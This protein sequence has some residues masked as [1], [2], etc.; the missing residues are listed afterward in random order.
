MNGD[1]DFRGP[2]RAIVRAPMVRFASAFITGLLVG[3]WQQPAVQPVL[4]VLGLLTPAVALLVLLPTGQHTRFQHGT[5]MALWAILFGMAWQGLREPANQ[6]FHV[7]RFTEH[8][9][10]WAVRVTAL[11]ATSG[12][13]WRADAALEAL[14]DSSGHR[15]RTGPVMLTLLKD[16]GAAPRVGDRLLVH[17]PLRPIDRVPDPGGFDRRAW[18]ASRGIAHEL[19]APVQRWRRVDHVPHWTGLFTTTRERIAAWLDG[20]GLEQREKAL[21]KALVLGQR[22]ELDHGQRDAFA[23]SGTIH[24]L[25]VSGMHV[26][27]IFAILTFLF[28]WWGKGPRARRLRGLCILLALWGYAGLT[29]ASPSVLRATIMFSL[30]TLANMAEQRTDHFNSLFAAAFV[31]LLWEPRMLGQIGFQL[32]FLAVLGI[33]LFYK[34]FERLWSP[35]SPVLQ[36]VRNL[37]VVSLAAQVLTTPVSLYLFKAFPVWF[38][39]ANIVVVT[40]V[41]L[42]VN[43]SVAL[44]LLY[45]VPVIGP[46]ITTLLSWL[47]KAVGWIT[48][49]IAAWPGAYPEVRISAMGVVL[50][51]LLVFALAAWW[52]WRWRSMRW[53]AGMATALLLVHWVADASAAR[54]RSAFVVY[55]HQGH[56]LAAMVHGRDHVVRMPP[57]AVP[58]APQVATKL[59]RHVRSHGLHQPLVLAG[60]A[61]DG[62][63]E[64]G[65]TLYA[66]GSWMAPGLHVAFHSATEPLTG[67]PGT[68]PP[69][70]LVLHEVQRLDDRVL[71]LAS[72]M[73][74]PVVLAAGVAWPVRRKVQRWAEAHGRRV[75][76]VREH[77]AF[78]LER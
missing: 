4:V 57:D 66:A 14:L 23:R 12:N 13:L 53:L 77:G 70:A 24:V 8:E 44:L 10:V 69:L 46:L 65:P 35:R 41:G 29:G 22:D 1:V 34:P 61:A 3:L 39:P 55:D 51:Y 2:W 9:G 74:G 71:E 50:L 38:L 60:P 7:A 40:A 45:K 31:L 20:S 67:W 56:L 43:G 16:D 78:V 54:R 11:N 21:V 73:D 68:A 75:H 6:P 42:A 58:D 17:A 28:G 25:A 64:A 48:A 5:A 18:A 27:L 36:G 52:Q 76:D 32:S 59:Q 33:I 49:S 15:A 62:L 30:F 19:F 26:G 37:A 47:L 63:R 72:R